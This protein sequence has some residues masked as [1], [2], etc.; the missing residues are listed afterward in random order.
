V[1]DDLGPGSPAQLAAR[2]LHALARL[3]ELALWAARSVSRLRQAAPHMQ[4]ILATLPR[5]ARARLLLTQLY[6]YL[7]RDAAPEVEAREV[8]GMLEQIAGPQGQEDIVNA[9]E[10]LIEQGRAEGLERGRTEG[11]ER[12]LERGR[13]EGLERGRDGLR[14][15]IATALMARSVSLSEAG[16]ARI[17][18]CSD[19]DTLTRWLGRAVTATSEA[20]VFASAGTP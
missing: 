17:A 4:A 1:L 10:Q 3:V 6:V 14:A 8:R 9:G 12:G 19:I 13:T 2:E 5:D 15:G 18:S 11:L 16:R 20:E 7:L